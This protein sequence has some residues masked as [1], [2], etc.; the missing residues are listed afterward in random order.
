MVTSFM[1]SACKLYPSVDKTASHAD[2]EHRTPWL[3]TRRRTCPICKGDVVRS[4]ARGSPSSPRYE[5]YQDDSDDEGRA[6]ASSSAIMR[7]AF[8]DLEADI[9]RVGILSPAPR[10]GRPSHHTEWFSI[11]SSSLGGGSIFGARRE[12][13]ERRDR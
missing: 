11:L 8:S 4:L 9:E 3:T 7:S 1:L 6:E 13:R 12:S 5:P 10:R 2:V